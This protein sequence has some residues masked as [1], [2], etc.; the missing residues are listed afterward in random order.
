M[1]YITRI[2]IT[3]SIE[4][5]SYSHSAS[6]YLDWCDDISYFINNRSKSSIL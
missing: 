6:R 1:K 4:I 3:I 5:P 2:T